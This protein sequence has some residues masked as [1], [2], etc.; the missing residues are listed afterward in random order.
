[1]SKLNAKA[2]VRGLETMKREANKIMSTVLT[3]E[4]LAK[5]TPEQL[6]QLEGLKT[7]LK[8]L[9]K[10]GLDINSPIFNQFK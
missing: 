10:S 4:L 8:G 3:P 1:M 6:V 2:M 7:Q 9:N 5:A